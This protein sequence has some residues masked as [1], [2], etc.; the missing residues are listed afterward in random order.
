MSHVYTIY[1]WL[2]LL[3]LLALPLPALALSTGGVGGYPANP[4]PNIQYSDSWFI[5]NLD[6]GESKHDALLLFNTSDETKTTK[7]YPVDS[8]PSNQGNFALK[9]EK[10][11]RIGIGAWIELEQ[12][13]ITLE[14]GESREIPFTI[15]I[16]QNADVGEHSGGIVIQRAEVGDVEGT[17]A[18]IVTR[19]G[20]RVYQ[21]V[22]G[23][24]IRD[25]KIL[26]FGVKRKIKPDQT[27]FFESSIKVKN[28]SNVTINPQAELLITGWGKTDYKDIEDLSVR[29]FRDFFTGDSPFPIRFFAGDNIS[30]EW[31]LIRDQEVSTRW[32]WPMPEFGRYTFQVRLTYDGADGEVVLTTKKASFWVVP[33]T[34]LAVVII[35]L[36]AIVMLLVIQRLRHSGKRWQPY[37]VGRRDRLTSLAKQANISWKKLAKVNKL[38]KPYSVEP[39][40]KI[41]VPPSFKQMIDKT[42][43]DKM[44]ALPAKQ[45]VASKNKVKSIDK[46]N[47]K[48][49]TGK[50]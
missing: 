48:N 31:Q 17:G 4:D 9:A 45:S 11:P 41:L 24:I 27:R 1:R 10:D 12:T 3:A 46:N 23:E 26:N 5:Y 38:K 19:V 33:L 28:L 14:P 13:L 21:T 20:I 40:Q 35:L 18:A 8:V 47:V 44:P 43:T 16:P 50:Q 37:V 36:G 39:G 25:L 7:I 15:T 29:K 34:E 30:R 42:T 2:L 32:E 6:V 49:N 22:P